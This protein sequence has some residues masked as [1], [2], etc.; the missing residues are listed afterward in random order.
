MPPVPTIKVCAS[1]IFCRVHGQER[2]FEFLNFSIGK[3]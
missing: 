2:V 3:E 1:G